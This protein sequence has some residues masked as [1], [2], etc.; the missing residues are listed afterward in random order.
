[1]NKGRRVHSHIENGQTDVLI[2]SDWYIVVDVQ[3]LIFLLADSAC[4]RTVVVDVFDLNEIVHGRTATDQCNGLLIFLGYNALGFDDLL[5][6][7][8]HP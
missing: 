6:M 8:K 1:M 4:S 5:F 2:G 3:F 7:E